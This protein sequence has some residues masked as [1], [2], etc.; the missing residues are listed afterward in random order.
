MKGRVARLGLVL[1]AGL[2][3]GES[4]SSLLLTDS[5]NSAARLDEIFLRGRTAFYR[6]LN[7][8]FGLHS[9]RFQ[10]T[11][12]AAQKITRAESDIPY[13]Y[14]KVINLAYI[15]KAAQFARLL[16]KGD[17]RSIEEF[18]A[19]FLDLSRDAA[20]LFVDSLFQEPSLAGRS[21]GILPDL[22][23]S[24]LELVLSSLALEGKEPLRKEKEAGRLAGETPSGFWGL[25]VIR[26]KSAQTV[27]R[28]AGVKIAVLGSCSAAAPWPGGP[29]QANAALF[30][31][32][33]GETQ[34]P[35]LDPGITSESPLP[36]G[37][38]APSLVAAVAPESEI[39]VIGINDESA[40][41]Y[42]FWTAYQI[43]QGIHKAV[44]RGTDVILVTAV[45]DRDY[46][47][48][49]AA[50]DYA[51]SK[52]V[53]VICPNFAGPGDHV[54]PEIPA[55]FPAHYN[56]TVAVAGVVPGR[57]GI[58]VPWDKSEHSHFTTCAAPT[59]VGGGPNASASGSP[60]PDNVP[61]AA[62]VAG[63]SA[64]IC[65][66][67]SK[68]GE[69]LSGQY[70]Q[71]IYEVLC[72]SCDGAVLGRPGFD[73]RTGYGLI[74]ADRAVSREVPA[75]KEKMTRVEANFKKRAEERA[76]KERE[77]KKD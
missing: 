64:L 74:D 59:A 57:G 66:L 45:F 35:W 15:R 42:P 1:A 7:L 8:G 62:L 13:L 2:I 60:V 22:K 24:R 28:G 11:F 21:A 61:A 27:S 31:K 41:V 32:L 72:R 76:A 34:A 3:L 75:Y 33:A 51:Y 23:E 18:E 56:T 37:G 17:P 73:P 58:P 48:L 9:L 43:S 39:R 36:C 67:L 4:A 68:T 38:W 70:V 16:E 20:S 50:C 26:A 77:S 30:V 19:L 25:E 40:G 47:F 52:N 63:T 65:S 46:R 14:E 69:E 71:R 5:K 44:D 53:V 54:S 12:A 6:E 29:P 55:H 49:K 10:L